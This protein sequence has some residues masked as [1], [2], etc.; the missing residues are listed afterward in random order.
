MTLA[1][2]GGMANM[3]PLTSQA[4]T[5]PLVAIFIDF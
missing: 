1:P 5:A 2:T 3:R 4:R